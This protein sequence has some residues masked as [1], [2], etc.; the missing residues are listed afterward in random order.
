VGDALHLVYDDS[1]VVTLQLGS[2]GLVK[3]AV[4]PE[5]TLG[6]DGITG[7]IV[8]SKRTAQRRRRRETA[9]ANAI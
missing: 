4:S 5:R 9:D 1:T 3:V 2:D 7:A 6:V 8:V